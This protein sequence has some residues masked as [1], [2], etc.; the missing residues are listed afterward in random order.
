MLFVKCREL[1]R[2]GTAKTIGLAM[3]ECYEGLKVSGDRCLV[4]QV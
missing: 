2:I 3:I 4:M 1:D